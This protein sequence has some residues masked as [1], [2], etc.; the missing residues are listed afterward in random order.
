MQPMATPASVGPCLSVF[1]PTL[2]PIGAATI[3]RFSEADAFHTQSITPSNVDALA[4]RLAPSAYLSFPEQL[5]YST[6]PLRT[7]NASA[8]FTYTT[9]LASCQTQGGSLAPTDVHDP[10]LWSNSSCSQ[11][12]FAS[13]GPLSL[14]R[15]GSPSKTTDHQL[16]KHGASVPSPQPER[17]QGCR[18]RKGAKQPKDQKAANRLRNRVYQNMPSSGHS[19]IYLSQAM[20]T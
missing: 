14:I 12:D 13:P 19:V 6:G 1:P 8:R 17:T 2:Y 15:L 11:V 20:L 3:R 4:H 16:P 9:P 7:Q 10:Y 5:R 18:A